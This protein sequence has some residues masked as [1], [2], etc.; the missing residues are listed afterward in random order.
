MALGPATPARVGLDEVGERDAQSH[1]LLTEALQ[2]VRRPWQLEEMDVAH[3]SLL[4]ILVSRREW[5]D[6]PLGDEG[7]G[8]ARAAQRT[9]ES[10]YT[11]AVPPHEHLPFS[12]AA[13]A[14]KVIVC[15]CSVASTVSVAASL[16]TLPTLFVIVTL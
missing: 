1:R 3:S 14:A 15:G 9:A 10:R 4:R 2:H 11:K 16:V 5:T 8:V 7:Q 12:F 6:G 13:G